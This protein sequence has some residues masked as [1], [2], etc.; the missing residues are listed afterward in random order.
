MAKRLLLVVAVVGLVSISLIGQSKPSIQGVWR[1]VEVTITSPKPVG[2]GLPKGTHTNLQPA[3]L[4]ITGK[5]YSFIADTAASPRPVTP[6]KVAA[7]PTREEAVAR[8]EPFV[9]HAGTYEISGD[10]ITQRPLV[11]K[12]SPNQGG[13]YF[14]RL[15]FKL[16]GDHLW[17][18]GLEN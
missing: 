1:P 2:R 17:M 11:N 5:H 3:L 8:W 15:T 10:V 6:F 7:E 12:A 14:E 9:A 13:G 4:T 16:D 18:T